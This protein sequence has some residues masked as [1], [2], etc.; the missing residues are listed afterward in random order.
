MVAD[1]LATQGARASATM[2]LT[3]L[4]QDNSVPTHLG[5]KVPWDPRKLKSRCHNQSVETNWPNKDLKGEKNG[6]TDEQT[7]KVIPMS[8]TPNFI[9]GEEKP[10]ECLLKL[11]YSCYDV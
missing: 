11:Y 1:V 5:L 10:Q 4:N 7:E 2:I 6:W 3:W 9:G 8:P